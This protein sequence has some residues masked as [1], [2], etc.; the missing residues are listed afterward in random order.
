MSTVSLDSEPLIVAPIHHEFVIAPP[1]RWMPLDLGELWRNRE[2][3]Q[4]LAWRDIK[5]RYKQTVL[6]AAWAVIQPLA[7]MLI[8]NAFFGSQENFTADGI[9]YPIFSFAALMPWMFFINGLSASANSLVGNANLITKVYFPRLLVPAASILGGLIDL[10]ITFVVM[11]CMMAWYGV[12]FTIRMVLLPLPIALAMFAAL[13]AGLWLSALNVK[14]RDVRHAVPFLCQLW[15]FASPVLYPS[16]LLD[17]KW[18]VLYGLNPMTGALEWFR[19]ALLPIAEP[20][21]SSIAASC[22]VTLVLLISGAWYFR[23]M[24]LHFADVV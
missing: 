12:P 2:L 18:R 5:V 21:T 24:E 6:G 11:I 23:S 8:F 16:S 13:G 15:M 10:S 3:L 20:P 4:F 1:K 22:A 7:T 17:S 14:Y 9:P 19:W